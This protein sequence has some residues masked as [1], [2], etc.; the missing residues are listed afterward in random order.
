MP[1]GTTDLVVIGLYL[2]VITGCGVWL[3]RFQTDSRAYFLGNRN[4]PWP[5][6]CLSVVAT[7]TSVLTFIGVP[8]LS[9]GSNMCFLQLSFGYLAARI[10]LAWFFL[11]AYLQQDTYTV[12]GYL[13]RRFGPL[14]RN[15][16][17]ALFFITQAL[18]SGVRL[19]AAALVLTTVTGT[20]ATIWAIVAMA[21]VTVGY[22]LL[23]GIAAVIWTDVVQATIMIG[24]GVLALWI[25]A[26]MFGDP[27]VF[28]VLAAAASAGKLRVFDF[29]FDLGRTYTFWSGIV[30]GTFLGMASHGTDQVL[31]QRL[32]TC[33]SL[34]DGRKAIIGSGLVIIPQFLLFLV[35]GVLLHSYYGIHPPVEAIGNPDRIFPHFIV[36][37]FPPVAAGLVVAAMLGAAMSTLDS[38]IQALSSS[39]VMDV[40][41]PLT[42]SRK[43]ESQYLGTSR[44]LTLFWGAALVGV[45]VLAGDWGPV[46]ETG[47]T[48][49][50]YTYGPLLGLFVLGFFTRL[51]SQKAA[52]IGVAAGLI[53]ITMVIL[54]TS[55]PWTWNVFVGCLATVVPA[56]AA[57]RLLFGRKAR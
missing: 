3:S 13:D 25:L 11:P 8:A 29:S 15:L 47:L 27:G 20:E 2:V 6:V 31:A 40:I 57:E 54:R 19:Y 53:V 28:E 38:A 55:L 39:T 1:L 43:A 41:R 49:A 24:G 18:G 26:G 10:I 35:V 22:T 48:V 51:S 12:Y 30:G 33:R 37:H 16:A 5:A 21:A 50:S 4:I 32:L 44:L 36:N 9:Y 14:A 17:S 23:G 42:G 52:A 7:E 34:S 45:A 46:L 56:L